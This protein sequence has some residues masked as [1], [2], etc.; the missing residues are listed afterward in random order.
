MRTFDLY[1]IRMFAQRCV[2]SVNRTRRIGP[3]TFGTFREID[4]DSW[5]LS[6]L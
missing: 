1:L 4:A 2:A 6:V 5:R 3:K